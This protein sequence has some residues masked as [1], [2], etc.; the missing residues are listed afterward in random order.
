[1]VSSVTDNN[2]PT[3]VKGTTHYTGWDSSGDDIIP[4]HYLEFKELE[5]QVNHCSKFKKLK[6]PNDFC[7]ISMAY[8]IAQAI[9]SGAHHYSDVIW[10][11]CRLKSPATRL[12][13]Q[14]FFQAYNKEHAN[15]LWEWNS[16]DKYFTRDLLH[17]PDC[18][19][20][21]EITWDQQDIQSRVVRDPTSKSTHFQHFHL[22]WFDMWWWEQTPSISGMTMSTL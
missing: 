10:V 6:I 3:T 15:A 7:Y 4:K 18:P 11:S 2:T 16:I 20:Q 8:K 21:Q 5:F 17:R 19:G 14:Q 9:I 12:F 1:M 22:F 13:L